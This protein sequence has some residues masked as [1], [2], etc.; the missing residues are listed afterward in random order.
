MTLAPISSK[1]TTDDIE[2]A[3]DRVA[4]EIA[5][6]DQAECLIPLYEWLEAQLEARRGRDD[7]M[8]RVRARLARTV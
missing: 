1:Y 5:E 2:T 8:A 6:N 4:L 3:L 7:T